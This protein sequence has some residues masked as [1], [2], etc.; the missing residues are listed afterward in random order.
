MGNLDTRRSWESALFKGAYDDVLVN[1]TDRCKYGCL[2]VFNDF[3]GI[4]GTEF[5]GQS[6]LILKDVRL[7]CTF[8]P[9]DSGR[10]AAEK[11][12]VLDFFAH[13]LLEY[14]DKELSEVVRVANAKQHEPAIGNS[15]VVERLKYKEAQIHG[16]VGFAENVDRL[17]V[18]DRYKDSYMRIYL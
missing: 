13:Q 14:S 8:S 17:V 16:D 11:L 7:R 4:G 1:P 3:R 5:Y 9:Q 18:E 6:Y 10:L 12:A 15:C 2:N